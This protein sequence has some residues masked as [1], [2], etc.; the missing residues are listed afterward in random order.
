MSLKVLNKFWPSIP[1]LNLRI[2]APVCAL[3][4]NGSTIQVSPSALNPMPRP[5]AV[6][7]HRIQAQ[8]ALVA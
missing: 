8:P 2:F 6:V 5:L 1:T 3:P 7:L 4:V